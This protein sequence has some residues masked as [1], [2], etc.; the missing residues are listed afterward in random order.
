MRVLLALFILAVGFTGA[1][2]AQ[3]FG[4]SG[5]VKLNEVCENR[6]RPG[7]PVH[8]SIEGPIT[9]ETARSFSSLLE[10]EQKRVA[11]T[12]RPIVSIQSTGGDLQAAMVIGREIRSRTG[13]IRSPG[14]CHSACVF[15]AMGGVERNLA[16]IGLHRPYFAY[17]D[18]NVF[19]E[20]DARYKKMLR[21]IADY[22]FEMNISEDL[23]RVMIS[24]P[25]G[26]MRLL[27]L[28]DARRLGLNGVDPAYDEFRTGQEAAHYGLTS[29][30]L[31]RRETALETQCGR[32]DE[33]RSLADLHKRDAC[34]KTTRER[35]MWGLDEETLAK[36]N[37]SS[38]ER[39]R[40]LELG[41][42]ERRMCVRRVADVLRSTARQ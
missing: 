41:S 26:E 29:M 11:T 23:L 9:P 18:A 5:S 16:G 13:T 6:G 32:E 36:L 4:L 25:P 19:A 30:E 14:P 20:A 10:L 24:V 35:I 22:M 2:R 28:P 38:E 3:T 34:R 7:C 1:A 42:P 39:C 15:A 8:L 21:L 17:A 37:R 12:L 27:P 40:D 33:M 31:R